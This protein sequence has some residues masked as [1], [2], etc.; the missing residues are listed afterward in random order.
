MSTAKDRLFEVYLAYQA[1]L[2]RRAQ[3]LTEAGSEAEVKQVLGNIDKLH[4]NYFKAAQSELSATGADVEQAL[5]DA[6]QASADAT[7]AYA[8]AKALPV[9]IRLVTSVVA[10]VGDLIRKAA[11]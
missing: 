10:K 1:A 2:N 3:D 7:A 5:K 6:K 9:R 8:A 11:G 4:S